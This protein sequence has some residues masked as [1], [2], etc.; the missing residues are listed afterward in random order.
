M[1]GAVERGECFLDHLVLRT[2]ASL[3]SPVLLV[4]GMPELKG[5][6]STLISLDCEKLITADDRLIVRIAIVV[7]K[8]GRLYSGWVTEDYLA[9]IARQT[10]ISIRRFEDDDTELSPY[11][12][13][14]T[15]K[16]LHEDSDSNPFQKNWRDVIVFPQLEDTRSTRFADRMFKHIWLSCCIVQD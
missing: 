8:K 5:R 10:N 4:L 6:V 7:E 14:I 12:I 1:A 16:G 13:D 3:D 2:S 15:E 11:D 9:R